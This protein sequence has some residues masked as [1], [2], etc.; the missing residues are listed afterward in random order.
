MSKSPV[1]RSGCGT[2]R[3]TMLPQSD[4]PDYSGHC[5]SQCSSRSGSNS[6]LFPELLGRFQAYKKEWSEAIQWCYMPGYCSEHS[7][8]CIIRSPSNPRPKEDAC[9]PTSHVEHYHLENLLS[10]IWLAS[11]NY[12]IPDVYETLNPR[13]ASGFARLSKSPSKRDRLIGTSYKSLW[14][15][16]VATVKIVT[17]QPMLIQGFAN[18]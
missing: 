3:P 2:I 4:L 17:C 10:H 12:Y 11:I 15:V 1:R 7:H 16:L 18:I 13:L 8:N 9:M 5:V 6:C 14:Y